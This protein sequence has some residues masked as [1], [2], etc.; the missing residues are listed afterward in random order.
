MGE[1]CCKDERAQLDSDRLEK[2]LLSLVASWPAVTATLQRY[3]SKN[4]SSARQSSVD[5][6][7][8]KLNEIAETAASSSFKDSLEG[9]A[10]AQ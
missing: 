7:S 6:L 2:R 8:F 9:V 4:W 5:S 3:M 10:T 1:H